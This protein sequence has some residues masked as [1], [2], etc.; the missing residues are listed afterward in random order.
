MSGALRISP[1]LTGYC[2]RL[3]YRPGD[4]L[5]VHAFGEGPAS[6]ELVELL[7]PFAEENGSPVPGVPK[8]ACTLERQQTWPGSFALVS[9][10]GA[11][12]EA[13]P[14]PPGFSPPA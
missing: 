11:A 8:V 7:P 5:A 6:L 14:C 2:D 1:D 12:A 3:N 10:E 13:W 4:I 9:T